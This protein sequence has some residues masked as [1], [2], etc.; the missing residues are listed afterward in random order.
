MKKIAFIIDGGYFTK[1]YEKANHKKFP[2]ADDVEKYILKVFE[3]LKNK[4]NYPI[5]I[6]RIFYY[7]CPPFHSL[8][9]KNKPSS[10]K[11]DDFKKICE[12]SK[13]KSEKLKKFHDKMKRKGFF[14]KYFRL[15]I[16]SK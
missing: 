16:Y 7:D 8:E 15:V 9:S 13:R 14:L 4:L 12:T 6:Y 10:M 1:K 11:G 2:T 5:E 3:Y